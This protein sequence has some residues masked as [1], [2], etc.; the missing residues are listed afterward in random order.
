MIGE[1][2]N[3]GES[4]VLIEMNQ[5]RVDKFGDH[6]QLLYIKGDPAEDENLVSAGIHVAEGIIILMPTDKDTLYVTMT[7]RMLNKDIRILS[8]M[9][10]PSLEPKLY[11]AG[12]DRV[13]SPNIIGGLRMASEMIRPEAVDFLDKMLRSEKGDL[14][15]HEVN[16][17]ESADLIGKKISDSG[18]KDR[19]D[20][21]ILAQVRHL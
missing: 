4:V 16:V 10:D 12:S 17:S 9:I 1:L 14:R 13:I 15:I 8:R 3:N 2:L 19:F 7:A 21:L 11:K 5:E 6:E 18:L 20:L